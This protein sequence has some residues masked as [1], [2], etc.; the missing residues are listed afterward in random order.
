MQNKLL[1]NPVYKNSDGYNSNAYEQRVGFSSAVGQLLP[2]FYDF[3]SPGDKL[4]I[5]DRMETRTITLDSSVWTDLTDTIDYFFVPMD[6]IYSLFGSM[7]YGVDD[8]KTSFVANK[9]NISRFVPTFDMQTVLDI[10]GNITGT[11]DVGESI[12]NGFWRLL[13]C[14]G[15]ST[16]QLSKQYGNYLI[17]DDEASVAFEF[18]HPLTPIF[19]CA[20]QKC[21]YDFY[22]LDDY[23]PNLPEAYNLDS[24]YNNTGLIPFGSI[25]NQK[26]MFMLRHR[27][28]QKDFFKNVFR[29]PLIPAGFTPDSTDNILSLI[30]TEF[31]GTVNN[32][33]GSNTHFVTGQSGPGTG[34]NTVTLASDG[35]Q[36]ANAPVS[37]A[38]N[39]S[40]LNT[41]KLNR[42]NLSTANLRSMF[43]LDKLLEVTRRSGKNYDLQTL[44]H[45]GIKTDNFDSHRV[46]YLGT[47]ESPIIV[48]DVVATADGSVS[49]SNTSIVGDVSGK[50]YGRAQSG[51]IKFTAKEHGIFLA[52]YSCVPKADYSQ[53]GYDPLMHLMERT[54]YPIPEFANLGMEPFFNYQA[55]LSDSLTVSNTEN[56][57]LLINSTDITRWSD[58]DVWRYR[59]TPFKYKYNRVFGSL[60]HSERKWKPQLIP[61]AAYLDTNRYNMLIPPTFLNKI[62]IKD[63]IT[64][65]F[66]GDLSD[67]T[68]LALFSSKLYESDPL[69]HEFVFDVVKTSKISNYGLPQL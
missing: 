51:D 38:P 59:Y 39:T 36:L 8:R 14:F 18:R 31:I 33:L 20:Y 57:T 44:A 41:I 62:V 53:L 3:L 52:I 37:P 68:K 19:F 43:A 61:F 63:Y 23:Q 24:M 66:A 16:T 67:S 4:T 21:Y 6:Q 15:I 56:S 27:P 55:N 54:D 13:D 26:N 46:Y 47:H 34:D 1:K 10:M 5:A 42:Y 48:R 17:A 25:S 58:F 7:F 45:F 49:D 11:D 12:A 35:N 65:S 50:G 2:V 22:R 40:T 64:D 28:W 69:L 30:H 32:W 9:S 60:Q 29:S